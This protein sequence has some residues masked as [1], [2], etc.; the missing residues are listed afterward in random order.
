MNSTTVPSD[1]SENR[2][3][4]RSKLRGTTVGLALCAAA[5][6]GGAATATAAP[7]PL[8][9]TTDTATSGHPV[10]EEFT[11]NGSSTLSSAVDAKVA[12]LFSNTF[13]GAGWN[14]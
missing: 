13:S 7:L 3:T 12:C 9:R 11:S 1:G 14:C 6:S 2:G 8:E 4:R 10:G 5:L